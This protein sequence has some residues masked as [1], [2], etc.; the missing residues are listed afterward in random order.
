MSSRKKFDFRRVFFAT[1]VV[2]SVISSREALAGNGTHLQPPNFVMIRPA[3][4]GQAFTAVA[5]DSN[6]L[7]YN[8]AGLAKLETWNLEV[9]N[10]IVGANAELMKN[11]NDAMDGANNTGTSKPEQLVSQFRDKFGEENSFRLGLNPYYVMRNFGVGLMANQALNIT[12][13]GGNPALV[14]LESA[15]DAEMRVGGAYRFMGDKLAVGA[16]LIARQRYFIGESM[17]Y[18]SLSKLAKEKDKLTENLRKK[19]HAGMGF[20]GDVGMLFTPVETWSPTLGVAILNV[21]DLNFRKI[22]SGAADKAPEPIPQSVNVGVSVTPTFGKWFLRSSFD[23]RDINLPT[24]AAKK[25]VLGVEAGFSRLARVQAGLSEG[26]PTAGIELRLF[27]VNIRYA[28]YATSRG[29]FPRDNEQRMHLLG[30]KVLL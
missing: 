30:L 22:D 7:Y 27:I 2:A 13:H 14:D 23:F 11:V 17:D 21:G 20:G 4:M 9:L 12:L 1:A 10:L 18:D 19:I 26:L 15:T 28:T 6:A 5:D 16:T 3:A 29:Y 8:P 24:P 25:P